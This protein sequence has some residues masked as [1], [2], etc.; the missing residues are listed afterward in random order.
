MAL[1]SQKNIPQKI[2]N[3]IQKKGNMPKLT[4]VRK[5][6][7]PSLVPT[8]KSLTG[9][10]KNF[11][12]KK[13]PLVLDQTKKGKKEQTRLGQRPIRQLTISWPTDTLYRSI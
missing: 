8:S 13:A 5:R 11:G 12:R 6:V 1:L 2:Q 3:Y 10:K 7:A 4:A 9:S